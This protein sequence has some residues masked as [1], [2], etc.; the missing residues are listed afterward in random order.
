MHIVYM[1]GG[2]G[3]QIFQYIFYAWLRKLIPEEDVVVDDG[4]FWGSDV[5]HRGYELQR[6]F[7][8]NIPLLSE[9]FTE[10]VWEYMVARRQQGIDI[11]EQ[12]LQAGL[13]FSVVREA[14][15]SNITFSGKIADY[16]VGTPLTFSR[17][18][19]IYWHGY[20]LSEVFYEDK[21]EQVKGS[22]RF[23]DF[24]DDLNLQ[25]AREIAR[26]TEPTAIH[27]RRGDMAALG[28]SAEPDYYKE[29]IRKFD[30]THDVSL[31]LL[32][33]DDLVWCEQQAEKLGLNDIAGR[34]WLVDNN[35]GKNSW[36]DLK[37]M[38][39]CK[40]RLSDRSSFSLLAG[41]LCDI[42]GKEDWN[43]WWRHE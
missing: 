34:L 7:A 38:S 24:T 30:A 32:F 26:A 11:P 33:S 18:A 22:L 23:P 4:K 39:M 36:C 5:P 31:Y 28:W 35:Q 20:W 21:K 1:N 10:D 6:I 42:S 14:N 13:D 19:N 27:I 3:N 43:R 40:H 9:R 8:I 25:L 12:L 37:L 17:T 2:L 15:V 16:A 29:M 41:V